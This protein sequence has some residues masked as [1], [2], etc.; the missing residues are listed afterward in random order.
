MPTA[1]RGHRPAS[2]TRCRTRS[3]T[4]GASW[5]G[6]DRLGDDGDRKSTRLLQSRQYL[7]CRLLLEKKKK[8]NRI[9][10]TKGIVGGVEVIKMQM[11]GECLKLNSVWCWTKKK[12][13]GDQREL[14]L[15]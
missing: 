2:S 11:L 14:Y 3:V 9:N 12:M 4:W 1:S 5:Q 6:I 10:T 15:E 7:V 8:R 13:V